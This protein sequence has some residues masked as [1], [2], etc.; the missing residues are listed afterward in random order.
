M[1]FFG[2][3][4]VLFLV[5]GVALLISPA[6][7]FSSLTADRGVSVDV[8]DAPNALLQID[9]TTN[10]VGDDRTTV[11][12]ITNNFN[13]ALEIEGDVIISG[14]GGNFDVD[15]FD[16]ATLE[17]GETVELQAECTGGQESGTATASVSLDEALG[18][19]ITITGVS[20]SEE[21]EYNCGS[22]SVSGGEDLFTELTA[23]VPS[24]TNE[25]NADRVEFVFE[26]DGDSEDEITFSVTYGPNQNQGS[27]KI[28]TSNETEGT[29]VF[30]ASDLN[31]QQTDLPI[32]VS[33][34]TE[35]GG[36]SGYLDNEDEPV[37]LC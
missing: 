29:V 12:K 9:V 19:G 22:D 15:D 6:F 4:A 2:K 34:E 25:G 33:V 16:G 11:V 37:D 5:A 10:V 31:T 27:S 24:T 14:D 17:S 18:G 1:H 35:E 28:V 23:E 32:Y 20:Y 36:C 26:Y 8:A 7:G 30:D 13:T 21:F 3:L